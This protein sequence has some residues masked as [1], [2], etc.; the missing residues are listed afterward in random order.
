MKGKL[1]LEIEDGKK[2]ELKEIIGLEKND[3]LFF[4]LNMVLSKTHIQE[5][6]HDLCKKTNRQCIVLPC[7]INE[8]FGIDLNG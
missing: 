7:F 5:L 6:E 3:I 8:V 2:I 4:K 1:L